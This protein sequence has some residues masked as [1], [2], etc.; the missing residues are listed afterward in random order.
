MLTGT[1]SWQLD[2]WG[3]NRDA[4]ESAVGAERAAEVDSQAAAPDACGKHCACVDAHDC[5]KTLLQLQVARDTLK[6]REQ[7]LALTP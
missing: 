2:F 4:Y 1:L 6:Q 3:K 7:V 5:R